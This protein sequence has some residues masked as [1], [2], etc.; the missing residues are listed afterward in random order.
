MQRRL[1]FLLAGALIVTACGGGDTPTP[2]PSPSTTPVPTDI[3]SETPV[4]SAA[5]SLAPDASAVP[6]SPVGG[7]TYKVKAND[8]MWA[9][10]REFGVTLAALQ[11]AN[12]TVD[13][14]KMRIGSIL[15]I[16]PK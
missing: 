7:T 3:F 10:S 8:T 13:P 1:A 2:Q 6:S 12:P 11:A 9:I 4:P 5:A 14:A 15:V 16:P